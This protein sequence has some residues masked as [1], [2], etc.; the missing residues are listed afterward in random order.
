M[1]YDTQNVRENFYLNFP[2]CIY[3]GQG[4]RRFTV[5]STQNTECILILLFIN[6]II[7]HMKNSKPTLAPPCINLWIK[8]KVSQQALPK[9]LLHGLH[10]GKKAAI[11]PQRS[12]QNT[13]FI[14]LQTPGTG[15][16]KGTQTFSFR[17]VS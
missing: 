4:K 12:K 7:F 2:Y 6:C 14:C 9:N 8:A 1:I 15:A 17:K 13:T 10:L 16:V 3:T 11:V 5:V